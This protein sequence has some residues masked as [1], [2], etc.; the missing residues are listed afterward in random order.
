MHYLK[1]SIDGFKVVLGSYMQHILCIIML[2]AAV[3]PPTFDGDDDRTR[4][5]TIL[6]GFLFPYH[7]LIGAVKYLYMDMFA[8]MADKISVMMFL[9]VVLQ[10][11]ICQYW[12]YMP[13][14]FYAGLT[15]KQQ[16]FEL[17]LLIEVLLFYGNIMGGTFYTFLSTIRPTTMKLRYRTLKMD[18]VG[19]YCDSNL[20][21]IDL[22][23]VVFVPCFVGFVLLHH[24]F[25]NDVLLV[26][27]VD[28]QKILALNNWIV[29]L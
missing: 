9:C 13:E 23:N 16:T 18:G 8:T 3:R 20:L 25:K 29:L 26:E 2:A 19:D 24:F 10:I 5:A 14:T 7:L 11:Y 12:V 15:S 6:Y 27:G 1:S 21:A 4:N 28:G 17:W 22:T